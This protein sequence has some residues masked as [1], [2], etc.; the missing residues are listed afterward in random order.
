MG[1]EAQIYQQNFVI[2][3]RKYLGLRS[4]LDILGLSPDLP[5]LLFFGGHSW[6]VACSES[7]SR[8]VVS[9][10]QTLAA[11]P[12]NRSTLSQSRSRNSS[13]T[14]VGFPYNISKVRVPCSQNLTDPGPRNNSCSGTSADRSLAVLFTKDLDHLAVQGCRRLVIVAL[15]A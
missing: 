4:Q 13:M 10:I 3:L 5:C 14:S 12:G 15:S 8:H 1:G 9:D 2:L 6:G 7:G 11:A